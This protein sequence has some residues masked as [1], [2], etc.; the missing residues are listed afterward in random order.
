MEISDASI[1]ISANS[2]SVTLKESPSVLVRISYLHHQHISAQTRFHTPFSELAKCSSDALSIEYFVERFTDLAPER[3]I[4]MAHLFRLAPSTELLLCCFGFNR[5]FQL[6]GEHATL[7]PESSVS[8]GILQGI[9]QQ[10]SQLK[11]ELS[12]SPASVS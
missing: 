11:M 4:N 12:L 5:T 9:P 1:P 3:L 2:I 6:C 10:D 7:F 8:F